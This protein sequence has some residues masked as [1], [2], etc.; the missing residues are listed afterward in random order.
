MIFVD[1]QERWRRIS[2][3]K[4]KYVCVSGWLVYNI[5]ICVGCELSVA[6]IQPSNLSWINSNHFCSV[7]LPFR[8]FC[9]QPKPQIQWRT[10]EYIFLCAHVLMC[11][12]VC[13]VRGCLLLIQI[14]SSVFHLYLCVYYCVFFFCFLPSCNRTSTIGSWV[15]QQNLCIGWWAVVRPD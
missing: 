6:S 1:R 5:Y 10:S 11:V 3:G 7:I 12:R 2:L 15:S 8:D 14:C 13:G 4:H 9:P